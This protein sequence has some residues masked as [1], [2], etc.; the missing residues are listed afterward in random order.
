[1]TFCGTV[2]IEPISVRNKKIDKVKTELRAACPALAYNPIVP[3]PVVVRPAGQG[4]KRLS[5]V[6][7]ELNDIY[8]WSREKI[9]D[10]LDT[11]D[12]NL[13]ITIEEE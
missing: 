12:V 11:L 6:I 1:M 7:M 5:V 13:T 2:L 10:W 8:L 4:D 3:H 9:A